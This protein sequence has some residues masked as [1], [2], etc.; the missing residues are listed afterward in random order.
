I[1][2]FGKLLPG[3]LISALRSPGMRFSSLPV[4]AAFAMAVFGPPAAGFGAEVKATATL[5]DAARDRETATVR[6]LIKPGVDVNA[7][8]VDGTPALHWIVRIDDVETAKL[9]IRAGAD[10]RLANRYGVRPLYLAS[11]NGNAEM[12]RVLLE[13]GADP[14]T[15]DPGG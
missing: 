11:A 6:S 9:L 8:G 1:S 14:N 4:I 13:A 12:I 10:V 2:F 3:I 5:A 7:P 15:L